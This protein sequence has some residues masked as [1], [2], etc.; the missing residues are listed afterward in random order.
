MAT[1]T[2]SRFH[3]TSSSS[4]ERKCRFAKSGNLSLS[5]LFRSAYPVTG[6]VI[7]AGR[8][9][10]MEVRLEPTPQ[11]SRIVLYYKRNV[12]TSCNL[13]INFWCAGLNATCT[14]SPTQYHLHYV[15]SSP[16]VTAN[17]SA[18]PPQNRY[19][20]AIRACGHGV[21]T[22]SLLQSELEPLFVGC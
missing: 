13:L 18:G 8:C 12:C 21:Y 9:V 20:H 14:S 5:A 4:A 2:T 22:L 6:C 15:I 10:S 3:R 11:E 1:H 17:N 7:T 16:W 19:L